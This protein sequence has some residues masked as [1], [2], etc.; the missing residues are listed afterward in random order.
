MGFTFSAAHFARV[1]EKPFLG[2]FKKRLRRQVDQLDVADGLS[3]GTPRPLMQGQA[4]IKELVSILRCAGFDGS[5]VLTAQNRLAGD[6]LPAA[7][8]RFINLLD[9]L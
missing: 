6:T 9:A 1:G 5:L 4:E 3:D 2:S 7:V 8:G